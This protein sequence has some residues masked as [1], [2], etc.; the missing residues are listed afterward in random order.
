MMNYGSTP[1]YYGTPTKRAT[2]QYTYTFKGWDKDLE[3]VASSVTYTAVFD[4][5]VNQYTVTWVTPNYV[6]IKRETL[7]YGAMPTPPAESQVP[8]QSPSYT[9]SY[10]F[11]GWDKE[12]VPVTSD[13][14]YTAVYTSSARKY[15]VSWF[16]AEG[17][18]L[19]R[20]EVEYN[21][22]VASYDPELDDS[23]Y[24]KGWKTSLDSANTVRFP[25]TVLYDISFY[26]SVVD[27]FEYSYLPLTDTYGVKS[28]IGTPYIMTIP[29]SYDDGIHGN[30]PVT[31][32]G[33]GAFGGTEI[34]SMII[35][36][37][38]TKIAERAF[39]NC[40]SLGTLYIPNSV[41]VILEA[42]IYGDTSLSIYCQA[43]SKPSGWNSY[44]NVVRYYTSSSHSSS[45]T[46]NQNIVWGY[47]R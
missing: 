8:E 5:T 34:T 46:F 36:D 31:E 26:A 25:Y 33:T 29:T 43:S 9:L 35:P 28:C 20:D 17:N 10:S 27:K 24:F 32:I 22:S 41:T 1:S 3:P 6:T 4:C 13:I 23:Q 7:D 2:A 37:T 16:D 42:A 40:A 18:Q 45:D 38:I 30:K 21:S 15:A 11:S 47:T 19:K 39:Q 14:T 44:W 12:V